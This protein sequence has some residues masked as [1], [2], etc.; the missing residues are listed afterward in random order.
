VW[1]FDI[2]TDGSLSHKR[3]VKKF[4]DHGFD[5]MRCDV[6]GNLYITRHGKGTVVKLSP[7]GELLQEI[8]VLGPHPTNICFGGKDGRTAYV[9]E[10]KMMRLVQFRVDRPGLEWKRWKR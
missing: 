5:G 6:D 9:T 10:A 7:K 4:E 3:L 2:I 8:D 1:A